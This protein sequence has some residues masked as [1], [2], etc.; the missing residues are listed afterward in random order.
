MK[1]QPLI[2]GPHGIVECSIEESTHLKIKIPGPTGFL[3]LP[4]IRSGIRDNTPCWTWNG[5][6]EKP[7][8]RPSLLSR[9]ELQTHT[10]ICHC[11]VNDGMVQFLDDCTHSHAGRT[12]PLLEVG[13]F[14]EEAKK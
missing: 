6:T 11:L 5:D 8:L 2:Q 12:I 14:I 9:I 1:A 3:I 10:I 13:E 7:T 4:I